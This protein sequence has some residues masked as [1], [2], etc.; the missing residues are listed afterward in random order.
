MLSDNLILL[1]DSYK[2]TH[3]KQYPPETQ[4][5]YS[6]YE[7]RGGDWQ[8]VVFF[9]LQY[10][11]K[12]Y[13]EGQVV[14]RA[15]IDEAE[16]IADLHFG[17]KGLFNRAMWEYIG[18]NHGGCLPIEIKAV[19]E[20]SVIPGHNVLMT[21]ENTDPACF[22]LTN[23]LETILTQIWYGCTVATQ[24][25]EM[26]FLLAK[27]LKRTGGVEGI[28][29]KLHDFGFRGVSSVETA[30]MG[31][32]AHLIN[33]K[34]T[35]TLAGVLM[36][37]EYYHEPM[38]GFSIPA[39]EHSTITAWGRMDEVKALAN[40]LQQ[41]PTGLVAV[42]SDSYDIYE[43]CARIWGSELKDKVLARDGT[44]VIRPDSGDPVEVLCKG[45]KNVLT[46]LGQRFGYTTNE[47]GFKVLNP[48]VR[49]IQGDGIDF[50]SLD[51]ILYA[52]QQTGWS[53]ENI[54]F[55][56]GGGLLQKLNRDTL[57]FAFKCAATARGGH[58]YPVYKSPV[59]DKGKRSKSGRMKLV[60]IVGSHG[61]IIQTVGLNEPG[62]DMLQ[63]VFKNGK[64]EVDQTFA[65]IRQ[66]AA[67]NMA[68][69]AA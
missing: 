68:A 48:K 41:Y 55:G 33:F 4:T 49:I 65:E 42:V 34:G 69:V 30:G 3:W 39:A 14:T 11:L 36:A 63:T 52:M 7:S 61:S 60:R 64:I 21:V 44:L 38:A 5:V 28:D 6:Y 20:G 59:T 31:G 16:A 57:R 22:P 37:R 54:A 32:A 24:S 51:A 43:A 26:K 25:R 58:E 66:R 29:F 62:E 19:P 67:I 9:G 45:E 23:Y 1:T 50:K 47:Q 13:L 27:Y 17:R 53:A 10:Y 2:V 8:N 56:S 15:K 46:L 12:R 18:K 40:M 35:D